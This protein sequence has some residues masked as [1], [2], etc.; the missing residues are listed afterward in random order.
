M[1]K[2]VGDDDRPIKP[3]KGYNYEAEA[4]QSM[5]NVNNV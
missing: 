5:V 2:Y 1:P 4:N 3:A